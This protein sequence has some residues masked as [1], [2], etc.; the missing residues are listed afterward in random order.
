M[1]VKLHTFILMNLFNQAHL[2]CLQG[3]VCGGRHTKTHLYMQTHTH[4]VFCFLSVI[5]EYCILLFQFKDRHQATSALNK[6]IP[7]CPHDKLMSLLYFVLHFAF[8]LAHIIE[9]TTI[10]TRHQVN[11]KS[12][13]AMSLF[14]FGF[15]YFGWCC[16]EQTFKDECLF[17]KCS[18]YFL[19]AV[20]CQVTILAR[21][22]H[23]D[24]WTPDELEGHSET[25][26]LRQGCFLE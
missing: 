23:D 1:W 16:R 17:D 26:D 5:P 8:P 13:N 19:L 4:C 25:A 15:Q 18:S 2:W 3:S 21:N 6:L 22:T 10:C 7:L 9:H 24:T 11:I 12:N 14:V 20:I